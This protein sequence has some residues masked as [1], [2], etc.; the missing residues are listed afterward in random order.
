M[1]LDYIRLRFM[2]HGHEE[3]VERIAECFVAQLFVGVENKYQPLEYTLEESLGYLERSVEKM[4]FQSLADI[5]AIPADLPRLPQGYRTE[6]EL[7]LSQWHEIYCNQKSVLSQKQIDRYEKLL[8]KIPPKFEELL[9][10]IKNGNLKEYERKKKLI[11]HQKQELWN[12]M[13]KK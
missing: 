3:S 5:I 9:E 6:D 13:T 1:I 10:A 8:Q 12:E 4:D 7:A 2:G 11:L